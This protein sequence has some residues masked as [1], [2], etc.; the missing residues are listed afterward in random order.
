MNICYQ[1]TSQW[2]GNLGKYTIGVKMIG[3]VQD[4]YEFQGIRN[5]FL[6]HR[7]TFNAGHGA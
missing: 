1:I 2:C 3:I 7:E 6:R 5:S 4:V